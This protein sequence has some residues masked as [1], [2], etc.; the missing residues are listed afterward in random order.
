[1]NPSLLE[2]LNKL[3][4]EL[5]EIKK[6]L[7]ESTKP[8]EKKGRWKPEFADNYWRIDGNGNIFISTWQENFIDE[9][10]FELGNVFQTK[11]LAERELG[12]RKAEVRLR[13]LANFEPDWED[14]DQDKYSI[15]YAHCSK[16]FEST[17]SN[18]CERMGQIYFRSLEEAE[19]AIKTHEKDLRLVFGLEGNE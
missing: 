12:R 3:E 18:L 11:E 15:Y 16:I 13:D 19:S 10:R 8:P 17:S 9:F 7:Q 1:M 2:R 6:E 4:S 14:L 5:S